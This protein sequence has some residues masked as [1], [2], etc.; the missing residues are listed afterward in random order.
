MLKKLSITVALALQ[1]R[2]VGIDIGRI[3]VVYWV[4]RKGIK[5]GK[6]IDIGRISV[7]YWWQPLEQE[8]DSDIDNGRIPERILNDE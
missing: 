7:V 4:S 8:R 3:S 1:L 5:N 6:G 2:L